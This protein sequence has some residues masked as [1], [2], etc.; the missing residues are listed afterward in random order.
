MAYCKTEFHDISAHDV[1]DV[2][3]SF[4]QEN[5]FGAKEAYELGD[6][7]FAIDAGENDIRAIYDD[8]NNVVKFFCRY[9]DHTYRYEST[10]KRLADKHNISLSY[11]QSKI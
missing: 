5:F 2:L 11:A 9:P 7:H 6:G 8:S 3:T 1:K 4:A 10:L